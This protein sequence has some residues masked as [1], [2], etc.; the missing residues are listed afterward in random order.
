MVST[1]DKLEFVFVMARHTTVTLHDCTKLLRYAATCQRLA[2]TACNRELTVQEIRK[3]EN[4]QM[5]IIAVL[6]PYDCEAKFGGDPRGC[7]VKIKVPDGYT[8][9]WGAEGICVPA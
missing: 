2:E 6:V 9:D 4:M 8:N 1:K 3:E 7:V 5:D